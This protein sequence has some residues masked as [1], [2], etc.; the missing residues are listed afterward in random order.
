MESK[1]VGW[2]LPVDLIDEV[3]VAAS[4]EGRTIESQAERLLRVGLV[5][6]EVKGRALLSGDV[7]PADSERC[8]KCGQPKN[9]HH[10]RHP[11]VSAVQS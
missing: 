10:N 9:D 7:T 6:G 11:F 1:S 5:I 4:K 2:R 3:R 8:A